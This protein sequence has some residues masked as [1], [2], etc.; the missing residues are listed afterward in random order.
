[1]VLNIGSEQGH[2]KGKYSSIAGPPTYPKDIWPLG[3]AAQYTLTPFTEL[4]LFYY[5]SFATHLISTI[6]TPKYETNIPDLVFS[7]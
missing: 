1:M 2:G 3:T 6:Q 7:L 4:F 5:Q